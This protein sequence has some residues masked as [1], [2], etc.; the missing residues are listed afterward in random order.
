[1]HRASLIILYYDQQMHNYLTN[2]HTSTFFDAI[3]SSSG[4]LQS[5]TCQVKQ[6]FQM[7]LLVI[8]FT[9][10]MFHVGFMQVLIL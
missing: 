6:V 7:Q 4:S 2:Y 10:K 1:M 5:I 9:I 8:Q 3:V